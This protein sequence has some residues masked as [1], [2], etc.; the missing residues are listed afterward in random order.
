[1][2]Q[3]DK[4][5]RGDAKP[6]EQTVEDVDLPVIT[7]VAAALAV[8]S[9]IFSFTTGPRA[10]PLVE[11]APT[12]PVLGADKSWDFQV[13]PGLVARPAAGDSANGQYWI[14]MN[15]ELHPGEI[16]Y[17]IISVW[18]DNNPAAP[19]RQVMGSFRMPEAEQAQ[20]LDKIPH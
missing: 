3:I 5:I 13:G 7:D 1:V 2:S 19:R 20:P 11:L 18:K 10:L 12:Q 9:V 14:D 8:Q 15:Q 17:Y 4:L 6:G 16:Y